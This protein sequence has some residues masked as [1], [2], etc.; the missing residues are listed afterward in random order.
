[1]VNNII[2]Y[3][4]NKEIQFRPVF[5]AYVTLSDH[6]FEKKTEL[7]LNEHTINIKYYFI[8]KFHDLYA[9]MLNFH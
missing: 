9:Q 8:T 5:Y 4:F 6:S 3:G 1:M 2:N 7:T